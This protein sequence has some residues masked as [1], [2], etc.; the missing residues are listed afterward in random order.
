MLK[1]KLFH[2][3]D[4]FFRSKLMPGEKILR[5]FKTDL[6]YRLENPLRS[7]A[8]L[9]LLGLCAI[10]LLLSYISKATDYSYWW[11]VLAT[12]VTIV[13]GFAS[14]VIGI[15][16]LTP[17]G[18]FFRRTTNN[19]DYVDKNS[20]VPSRTKANKKV[21]HYSNRRSFYTPHMVGIAVGVLSFLT[22]QNGKIPYY[23]GIANGGL[24]LAIICSILVIVGMF[25][26][27]NQ[28]AMVAV[29]NKR[30][31]YRDLATGGYCYM[32]LDHRIHVSKDPYY[33]TILLSPKCEN[34]EVEEPTLEVINETVAQ[35]TKGHQV[36]QLKLKGMEDDIFLASL[37][38]RTNNKVCGVH[39]YFT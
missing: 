19:F 26:R 21:V 30:V 16:A 38:R 10:S 33:Y 39:E 18:R 3:P 22:V 6:N 31:I 8:N 28:N 35:Y 15:C 24:I 20:A 7:F 32:R 29:T 13:S 12:A 2:T 27:Y 9:L 11:A 36:G 25:F 14:L 34:D 37:I 23:E 5:V 17:S 1:T 4:S